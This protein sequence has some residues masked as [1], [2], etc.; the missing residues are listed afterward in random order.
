MSAAAQ[1]AEGGWSLY[2]QFGA[3]GVCR[4]T[5]A[6]WLV[7][8]N[9]GQQRAFIWK[10]PC[11]RWDCEACGHVNRAK[12]AIRC[13]VG[14]LEAQEAGRDPHFLTLTSHEKLGPFASWR[15]FP[16][17]W[18]KLR[19]RATRIVPDG[20][21]FMV[22]EGHQDGRC[23]AHAVTTFDMPSRWWKDNARACGLGFMAENEPAR[24]P[25]GGG[26]Y[27]IKY[28]TK[29]LETAIWKKGTRHY[30]A[31]QNWPDL[32]ILEGSQDWQFERVPRGQ[33][34][35]YTMR[36]WSEMGFDVRLLEKGIRVREWDRIFS[37]ISQ[38]AAK[39]EY[40]R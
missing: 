3:V 18:D 38:E 39:D 15:V 5:N 14:V 1:S 23:H 17:A 30:N 19:R 11:N 12:A 25:A 24:T 27:V 2:E 9:D 22:R 36:L 33:T 40:Q 29:Q 13:Y 31:S 37:D 10:P 16:K 21:Y 8:W 34:I 32:P 6:P 4:D 20:M 35:Q 7:G 26:A 28:L